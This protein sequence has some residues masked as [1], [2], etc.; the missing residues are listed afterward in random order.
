MT[1]TLFLCYNTTLYSSKETG[2]HNV[3]YVPPV[4]CMQLASYATET[5]KCHIS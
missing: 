1:M 3:P 2:V 5:R 4:G